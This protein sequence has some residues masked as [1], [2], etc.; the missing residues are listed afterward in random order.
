[1]NESW[2]MDAYVKRKLIKFFFSAQVTSKYFLSPEAGNFVEGIVNLF[3]C[4]N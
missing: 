2:V 3:S 4:D 1:M